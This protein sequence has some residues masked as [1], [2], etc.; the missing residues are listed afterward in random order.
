MSNWKQF[1]DQYG[2]TADCT[3][4][5][6]L[7]TTSKIRLVGTIFNGSTFDTNFWTKGS[8]VNGTVAQTGSEMIIT[9]G[10]TAADYAGVY[11]NRRA[12]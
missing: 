5:S 1:S 10:P 8:L 4:N 6:E 2:F 12:N 7:I 9:S 11:S 3:S